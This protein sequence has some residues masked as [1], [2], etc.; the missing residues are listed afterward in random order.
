MVE[1]LKVFLKYNY[2]NF[3][4]FFVCMSVLQ[5][6]VSIHSVLCACP[7]NPEEGAGAPGTL[8]TDGCKPLCADW[9]LNLGPLKN[10]VFL[11]HQPS[12]QILSS[13]TFHL[14]FS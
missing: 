9:E 12:L 3:Y 13:I 7:Q 10:A 11:T 8:V 2:L 4:L 1:I 6:S 5:V 14:R